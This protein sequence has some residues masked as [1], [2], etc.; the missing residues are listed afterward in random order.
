MAV[1]D[2]LCSHD[3]DGGLQFMG[4]DLGDNFDVVERRKKTV[5]KKTASDTYEAAFEITIR[6]HN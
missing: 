2:S 4:E 6:N 3:S 1:G 5:W